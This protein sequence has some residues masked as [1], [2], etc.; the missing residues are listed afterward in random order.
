MRTFWV[1]FFVLA[2]WPDAL[3]QAWPV[4]TADIGPSSL[5]YAGLDP[6][7][8]L[9]YDGNGGSFQG[10]G[11]HVLS[12][13]GIGTLHSGTPLPLF[14]EKNGQQGPAQLD[15]HTGPLLGSYYAPGNIGLDEFWFQGGGS[16]TVW[17]GAAAAGLNINPNTTL[18]NGQ[19]SSVAFVRIDPKT[20]YGTFSVDIQDQMD[21]SLASYFGVGPL[22]NKDNTLL[23]HFQ[24]PKVNGTYVTP[25]ASLL[26]NGILNGE[27]RN[28]QPTPEP[29]GLVLFVLG[30]VGLIGFAWRRVGGGLTQTL[31]GL[32]H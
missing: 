19:I 8:T 24:L 9:S 2:L 23:I 25:G 28:V 26:S 13:N 3:V 14:Q 22:F 10:Q 20:G 27:L 18:L 7:P 30:L 32:P 1:C 15:F 17:G 16:L 6:I 5:P 21:G 4:L 12:M 29:G 11:I 31:G